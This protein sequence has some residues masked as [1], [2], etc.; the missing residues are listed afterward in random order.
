MERFPECL[1]LRAGRGRSVHRII[2]EVMS[3][4]AVY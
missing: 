4:G 3:I 1:P 2:E